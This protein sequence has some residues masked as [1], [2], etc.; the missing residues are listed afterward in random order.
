MLIVVPNRLQSKLSTK[1]FIPVASPDPSFVQSTV[2]KNVFK[3]IS[4]VL[5]PCASVYPNK[6]Q[7]NSLTNPFI[8]VPIRFPVF[9]ASAWIESHGIL[10]IALLSFPS[11]VQSS[12]DSISFIFLILS[13]I[14]ISSYDT[15]AVPFPPPLPESFELITFSSSNPCNAPFAFLAAFAVPFKDFA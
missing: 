8:N 10:F 6:F 15:P 14:G 4:A 5:I 12:P 3:N 13:D 9:S 7:S 1:P 11:S 2:S